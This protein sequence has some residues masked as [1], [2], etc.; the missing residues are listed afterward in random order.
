M[1][2]QFRDDARHLATAPVMVGVDGSEPAA[3]AVAWAA[4]TA[5]HRGRELRIVHGMDLQ[6]ARCPVM[7]VHDNSGSQ[8]LAGARGPERGRHAALLAEERRGDYM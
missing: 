2:A 8:S 6:H 4:E 7:V 5:A 3:A 1:S